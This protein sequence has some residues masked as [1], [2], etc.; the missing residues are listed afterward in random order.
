MMQR[1]NEKLFCFFSGYAHRD[2]TLV[3]RD[4]DHIHG[5]VI[6]SCKNNGMHYSLYKGEYIQL[7]GVLFEIIDVNGS[8]F[9]ASSTAE[10]VNTTS[11]NHAK[12]GDLLT[13]SVLAEIDLLHDWQWMLHPS[14]CG[15][16]TYKNYSV[17]KGHEHTLKLDF[18]AS[19]EFDS[20]IKEDCHIGLAGSSLTAREVKPENHLL[21]F[22]IY[23]GRE[24]RENSQFNQDLQPNTQVNLTAPAEIVKF[25]L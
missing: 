1:K 14:I 6:L 5:T 19:I 8:D 10:L 3:A 18:E 23:C 12:S 16:V 9:K 20:I 13:L 21:K 7:D 2:I 22:S 25:N 4:E 15:L 24:T 17:Q 11:L